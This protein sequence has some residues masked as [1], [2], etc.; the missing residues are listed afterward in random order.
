[1][2]CRGFDQIDCGSW[3]YESTVPCN[4]PQERLAALFVF[5]SARLMK[6]IAN[7]GYQKSVVVEAVPPAGPRSDLKDDIITKALLGTHAVSTKSKNKAEEYR[8]RIGNDKMKTALV[9][10]YERRKMDAEWRQQRDSNVAD[11]RPAQTIQPKR[12][13][14][15]IVLGN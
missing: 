8:R 3:D 1:M 15:D 9:M 13:F 7:A 4:D 14:T 6:R 11:P 10:S 2:D 12:C 5:Y